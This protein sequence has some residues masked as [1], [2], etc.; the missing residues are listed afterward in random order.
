[1]TLAPDYRQLHEAVDSLTPAQAEA[2]FD[3]VE[4]ML[5]RA[6]RPPTGSDATGESPQGHRFSFTAAGIGPADLAER[7]DDYLRAGGF[8]HP[9]S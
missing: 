7:A 2:L 6:G 5:G 9:D 1:M 8:G 3:F 4:S